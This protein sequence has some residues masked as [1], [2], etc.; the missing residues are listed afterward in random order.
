VDDARYA[1]VPREMLLSGDWTTPTLNGLEYVEKPPLWYWLCA[2]SYS[3]FGVSETTA[4]LPL[5]LLSLLT[6]A[7]T[8]WLGSWLYR[9]RVG[10]SAALILG[11][12]GLFLF[13]A[14]Y[15]TL[16]LPLT[17]CLL[18][19]TALLLRCALRPEDARWA[20]PL[21]W[22]FCALAFLS[23]GL[24]ALVFP[25]GWAVCL[26]AFFPE[27]R[28]GLKTLLRP[29]GPLIFLLIAVPWFA[30][31]RALHADFFQFFFGEQ[32]F[33]RFMTQKYNRSSPW[34]YYLLVVPAGLL[35]WTPAVFAGLA[36][37]WKDWR[38]KDPRAPALALWS[39]IIF[40]FFSKSQSKLAAYILPI[41]P[42]LALLAARA[43][44]DPVARWARRLAAGLG[45]LLLLAAALA[46]PVRAFLPAASLPPPAALACAV[47]VLL[48]IGTALCAFGSSRKPEALKLGA[49]GLIAALALTLGLRSAQE[50]LSARTL[51]KFI[52]RRQQPGDIVYSYGTYLHGLPFY[53]G[54][55]VE[56]V[57]NWTGELHYGKRKFW[58]A[59]RFGDDEHIWDLPPLKGGVFIVAR[60]FEAPYVESML[61]PQD[62]VSSGVFG[63]WMVLELRQ[64]PNA[65]AR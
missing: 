53:T 12:M 16:D 42:H 3:I 21:T 19:C 15:I 6:L 63:P 65:K 46:Y 51:G 44:E 32:H 24:V 49:A 9:P 58:N 47:A 29:A 39:L 14:Q 57:V 20:A 52:S 25:A 61:W 5:A 36:A 33:Q 34:F 4:H 13:H 35:P 54:R 2:A 10:A 31:M 48:A 11:T 7:G 26:W 56:R 55:R 64:Q 43:L 41:F 1:A 38:A 60:L 17:A 8:A 23:K 40:A 30:A 28:R 59:G 45:I 62:I 22:L 27:M 18:W 37:A 50:L